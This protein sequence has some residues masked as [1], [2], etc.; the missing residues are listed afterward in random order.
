MVKKL[1][2]LLFL[3]TIPFTAFST[4]NAEENHK[5]VVSAT[6]IGLY[7]GK[8][9]TINKMYEFQEKEK[10]LNGEE[11]IDK[12]VMAEASSNGWSVMEFA[13]NCINTINSVNEL[14]K[15]KPQGK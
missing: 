5:I 2:V 4:S 13:E 11:F 12:F 6:D 14:K 1:N 9:S 8:C 15:T 7:A 3:A 10:M